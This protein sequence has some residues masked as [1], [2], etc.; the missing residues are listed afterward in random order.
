MQTWYSSWAPEWLEAM[1]PPPD[2]GA[3]AISQD[4]L[5]T[6]MNEALKLPGLANGWTM[7]IKGRIRRRAPASE[8]LLASRFPVM[9]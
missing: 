8:P 6:Q 5:M 7:P 2:T 3:T 4:E 9:T 1:L